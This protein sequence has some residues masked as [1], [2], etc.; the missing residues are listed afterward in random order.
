MRVHIDLDAALIAEVD[1]IAGQ[2]RRSAFVR[3]AIRAAVDSH[4]RWQLISRSAGT[5]ADTGHDWDADPAEWV[6]GQRFGDT[7]RVG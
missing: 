3:E 2:R 5:I 6:H 7:A 4:K 1:G